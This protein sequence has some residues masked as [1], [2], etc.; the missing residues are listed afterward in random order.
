MN[1]CM[2]ANACSKETDECLCSAPIL[3]HDLIVGHVIHSGR[4]LPQKG[5]LI[6]WK[7]EFGIFNA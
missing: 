3:L 5:R 6:V 4:V 7:K 1:E 2:H